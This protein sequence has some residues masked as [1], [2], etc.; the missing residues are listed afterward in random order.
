MKTLASAEITMTAGPFLRL[1]LM[2]RERRAQVQSE[3]RLCIDR[4]RPIA[5]GSEPTEAD[6]PASRLRTDRMTFGPFLTMILALSDRPVRNA[7]RR[8]LTT[9]T[10]NNAPPR[11]RSEDEERGA[12]LCCRIVDALEAAA[13]VPPLGRASTHHG[14]GILALAAAP[15][16]KLSG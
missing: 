11:N 1:L 6:P 7:S 3:P 16:H 13:K 14:S 10:R 5:D 4:R 9:S 8:Q 12:H 2:F 15:Q